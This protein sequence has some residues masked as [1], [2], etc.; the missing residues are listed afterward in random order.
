MVAVLLRADDDFAGTV[1]QAC[2][3]D[4]GHT[5]TPASGSSQLVAQARSN[6]A[7][8]VV[9]EVAE[10]DAQSQILCR[11]LAAVNAPP[12]LVVVSSR[13]A[14]DAAGEAALLRAGADDVVWSPFFP[15][16]LLARLEVLVRRRVLERH[17]SGSTSRPLIHAGI[18]VDLVGRRAWVGDAEVPLTKVEFNILA[19]LIASPHLVHTRFEL[20]QAGMLRNA[21]GCL[22]P[23]LSRLRRKVREAGG[24]R[25]AIAVH[26]SGFR[27]TAAP[28]MVPA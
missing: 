17:G 18:V 24:P 3:A 28:S 7:Q 6:T 22:D 12:I 21:D 19:A 25:V 14:D 4:A 5:V 20:A 1:V 11:R 13:S 8:A 9:V 26:G 16:V 23:H 15:E 27:L 2:L 10:A